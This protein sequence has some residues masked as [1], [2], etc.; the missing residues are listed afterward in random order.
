MHVGLFFW[1]SVFIDDAGYA[2]PDPYTRHARPEQFARL[3]HSLVDWAKLADRRGFSSF[4][5]TE[6]HFQREGYEVIPNALLTCA[7]LAQH[8]ERLK[9]GA[10]FHQV[11]CWHP[12][13]LAEDFDRANRELFDEHMAI[14]KLAWSQPNFSYRGKFYT[15]PPEGLTDRGG[16]QGERF[17]T[18]TLVPSP[19]HPVEIWQALSSEPTFHYAAK[20]RH[21][22]VI[23]LFNRKTAWPKWKLSHELMERYQQRT[24]RLGEDRMLVAKVHL[25]DSRKQA[26]ARI[27]N[28]H[29]E[30]VRFLAAQRP[31]FGYLTEDGQPFPFGRIPTLEESMQQGGWFVGSPEEV[32]DGLL[33]LRDE[34]GLENLAVEMQYAGLEPDQVSEQIDRFGREIIPS[35]QTAPALAR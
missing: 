7:I 3:Y 19:T 35:L 1:G 21:K 24:V 20:E 23:P 22:G 31:L 26:M 28:P 10:M 33:E 11:V 17:D 8:T 14:I 29:D 18:L 6:H 16:T 9:F 25:A 34:F 32:R 2:G 4:W 30:R 5:L 15:L 13:R 27:R 12:L